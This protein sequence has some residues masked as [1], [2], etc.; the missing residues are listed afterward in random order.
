[1]AD[2]LRE[3]IQQNQFA[4]NQNN[5]R[6]I[7]SQRLN[8][9]SPGCSS[10][11][12]PLGCRECEMIGPDIHARIEQRNC[13]ACSGIGGR[14]SSCLAKR[15]RDAGQ[16]EVGQF[17]WSVLRSWQHMVNMKSGFLRRLRQIAVLADI[18]RT[19]ANEFDKTHGDLGTHC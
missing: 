15:T 17:G 8:G 10:T 13:V 16:C 7:H 4:T 5:R 18:A 2:S 1:M 6:A 19:F 11:A 14:C 9:G 12:K 3:A